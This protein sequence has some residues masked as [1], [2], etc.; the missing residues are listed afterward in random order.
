MHITLHNNFIVSD[1]L[2]KVARNVTTLLVEDEKKTILLKELTNKV[3]KLVVE[4]VKK[5]KI[6]TELLEELRRFRIEKE[7]E[8][9]RHEASDIINRLPLDS[10]QDMLEIEHFLLNNINENKMVRG[11]KTT[12]N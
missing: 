4:D 1:S 5:T 9:E 7:I 11:Y 8:T 2:K 12:K 6:L 10:G 3:T